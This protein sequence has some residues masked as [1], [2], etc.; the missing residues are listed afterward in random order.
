MLETEGVCVAPATNGSRAAAQW[1]IPFRQRALEVRRSSEQCAEH[2]AMSPLRQCA[3]V[4]TPPLCATMIRRPVDQRC[5]ALDRF[6]PR[7]AVEVIASNGATLLTSMPA[8]DN[9]AASSVCQCSRR[10][11]AARERLE[12]SAESPVASRSFAQEAL[13]SA[14]GVRGEA[15]GG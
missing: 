5:L 3:T 4:I 14:L 2:E 7:A 12:R 15:V 10:G 9:R 6:D 11:R 8:D 13:L 1:W